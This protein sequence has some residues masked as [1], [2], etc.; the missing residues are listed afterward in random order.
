MHV[1]EHEQDRTGACQLGQHAEHRAE[2]LLLHQARHVAA[3]RLALVPVRQQP[4]KDG[5]RGQRVKQHVARRRPGASISQSVSQRQVGHRVAKLGTAAGQ[6]GETMLARP[7]GQL[8]D[9]AR[10]AYAGVAADQRDDRPAARRGFQH[11]DQ[12]A[13]LCFPADQRVVAHFKH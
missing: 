8:G 10:L 3:G 1:L 12:V 4:R 5:P 13:K 7:A 6:D 11:A 9:Q 2:E